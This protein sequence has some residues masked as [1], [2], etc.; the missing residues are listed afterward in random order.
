[1]SEVVFAMYRAHTGKEKEL[2]K[3][4]EK[5]VL[6]LR[7]LE[8][9]THRPKLTLKSSDSTYIE[10]IE[11]VDVDATKKAHEHPAVAKVWEA[12]AT[13]SDFRKLLDLPEATKAFSHFQVVNSLSEVFE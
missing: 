12:M 11:W 9:V 6:V 13:V 1:M 10:I 4:I 2:E 8:L 5:H 7:E 3:L